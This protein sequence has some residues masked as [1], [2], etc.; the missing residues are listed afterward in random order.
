MLSDTLRLGAFVAISQDR[1]Y[2]LYISYFCVLNLKSVNVSSKKPIAFFLFLFSFSFVFSQPQDDTPRPAIGKIKGVIQDYKSK[3]PVEFS[4]IALYRK[5][6]ST[7]I[8]GTVA[9]S[10]GA[11]EISALE[12][13]RYYMKINFIGYKLLTI[14]TL[15]IRPNRIEINM[16]TILLHTSSEQL[17]EVEVS[18]AKSS[19]T[20]GIDRK[21]FN[22]EKSIV[23]DGGSAADVLKNIPSV[24]VDIDGNV[25]LRGSQNVTVLVD[26]R[27][28]SI[29]GTNKAQILQQLPA[30][31]IE[32]IELIT[33]PSAKYDPDGMSGIINIVLKKNKLVGLNGGVSVSVGT[34]DKYSG[35][36]NISYRNSKL[37]VFSNYGFRDNTRTGS[38]W[39]NRQNIL[40]DTS[41]YL[42]SESD[43]RQRNIS[44][45][46]K[47]GIDFYLDSKNT[48]GFSVLGNTGTEKSTAT[49]FYTEANN[50]NETQASYYRDEKSGESPASI[51]YNMNFRRTFPKP[52]QELTFDATYSNSSNTSI[53]DYSE[54]EYTGKYAVKNNFPFQQNTTTKSV[55]GVTNL[56]LDYTQPLKKQMKIEAGAKT[57]MRNIN[58]KF[59]SRTYNY[60][61]D[62][63]LFDTKINNNF[64][65]KENIYAAYAT[66][67]GMIKKLGYQVG[68]RA[69]Q[70]NT[71]SY[72]VTTG[73][74]FQN[75]Y[76]NFFPSVHLSDKFNKVN[77]LQ[78]SYSRRINR[79]NTRSLNPFK[80]M[81]DPYNVRMGNPYLKPEYINSYELSYMKYW[82]KAVLTSSIYYRK[83]EGVISRIK[84]IGDSTVSYTTMV[85]LTSSSS[86]GF[87]LIAKNDWT[88]WWNTTASVN[89]FE[90]VIDGSN[91]DADLQNNN[92]SYELKL[93]SNMKLLKNMD[94]QFT[95]NYSGPSVTPQGHVREIFTMDFGVK[96]EIFRNA[97][98]SLNISDL[99]NT[100]KMYME[101]SGINFEQTMMRS[102]ES[103]VATLTFA[104][105]FG[106]ASDKQK[107]RQKKPDANEMD[108]G[109]D[110]GM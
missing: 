107:P 100:R 9:D 63:F 110:M 16:G 67:Q 53:T 33:N 44:H 12:F 65:Y 11:F 8:T 3:L 36:A 76:F 87:E 81:S 98:L 104:Y 96:K 95:A 21:I 32:S 88:K 46:A 31:S 94:V 43:S 61:L 75:N 50:T 15:M 13:R 26:G 35:S 68:V 2:I 28:S 82:E 59:V 25:S 70:A 62:E 58:S 109:G 47:A 71:S 66:F 18:T 72:L 84:T 89:L 41:Y 55:N 91:V 48:L 92:F 79:P 23:S 40:A 77:E 74:Q 38:G 90:T 29:T 54:R 102:R 14:D 6:D 103:R 42:N 106:K 57:I 20:L 99:T 69:E 83:T 56:Q 108:S 52:K 73:E 97:S 86:Y 22:V 101:S 27:P 39:S 30:S 105:R 60:T 7:L 49:S 80:D 85:N 17:D 5:K 45:N 19:M 34:F 10:K 4:T 93:I 64:Q 37:N 1:Y 24:S 78:L 51:D